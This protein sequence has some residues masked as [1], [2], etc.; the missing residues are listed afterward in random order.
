M[1]RYLR[2]S[3]GASR[4]VSR[5]LTVNANYAHTSGDNLMRG[6]NLNAPGRR[7]AARSRPS[8]TSCRSW[9]T[10]SRRSTRV[11]VGASINFNVPRTG[12]PAAPGGPVMIGGGAG[13]IMI[14]GPPPPPPP[15]GASNPA[16]ARWNW[17]RMSDVHEL[18]LRPPVQ[19]HRRARSPCPPPAASRTTGA[20]RAS[21]S[22][23]AFN[24]SW[25][26][27]QLR[28]FNANLNFNASSAPPY[29]IRTGV[30]TNNDLL[31]TDRPKAS[32]ATRR[33][34]PRSGT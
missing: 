26:S 9:A 11:N 24:L 1:Q 17:R 16:N 12:G 8:P 19:Q 32:A 28:N 13:M 3:A 27:T 25:S 4:T 10:P 23:A 30:D 5:M 14:S 34:R 2:F 7:R 6:L 33:A 21:T 29:T 15:G 22:G 18:R 20:R 31:F